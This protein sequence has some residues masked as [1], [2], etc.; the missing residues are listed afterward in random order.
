MSAGMGPVAY[1]TDGRNRRSGDSGPTEWS[2]D[3]T[4]RIEAE[5]QKVLTR[6]F[7]SAVE[8]LS[9]RRAVLDGMAEALLAQGSLEREEFLALLGDAA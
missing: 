6:A 8:T 9:R 5:V 4:G 7:D 1:Q 2:E 3:V